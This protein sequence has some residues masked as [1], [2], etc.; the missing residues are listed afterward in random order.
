MNITFNPGINLA[1]N[2]KKSSNNKALN[3]NPSF[4]VNLLND[5]KKVP[6]D[7]YE[8]DDLYY[9]F[10]LTIKP[11]AENWEKLNNVYAKSSQVVRGVL[12]SIYESAKKEPPVVT[13]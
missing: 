5:I 6:E 10:G 7:F 3:S 4:G 2:N 13:G 11:T 12:K 8:A 1:A 9:S